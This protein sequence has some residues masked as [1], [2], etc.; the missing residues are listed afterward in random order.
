VTFK[1]RLF[2]LRENKVVDEN[3]HAYKTPNAARKAVSKDARGWEDSFGDLDGVDLRFQVQLI[4][5]EGNVL[6]RYVW[7]ERRTLDIF[8]V[9][10]QLLH[11]TAT[12]RVR[13]MRWVVVD[14]KSAVDLMEL[15][16]QPRKDDKTEAATG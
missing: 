5:D 8:A 12:C 1:L 10:G 9:N 15:S 6:N 16:A 13:E 11:D 4:D 14:E 7:L 2:D 3:S